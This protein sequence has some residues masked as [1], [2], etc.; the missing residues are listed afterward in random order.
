MSVSPP[1]NA[2]RRSEAQTQ[3]SISLPKDLLERVDVAAKDE[4][5]NRSN[6][7]ATQLEKVLAAAEAKAADKPKKKK[8][9]KA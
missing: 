4:N 2:P 1:V 9:K 3:I 7:I 8:K 5:R 6:Y